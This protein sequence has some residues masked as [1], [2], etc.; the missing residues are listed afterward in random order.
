MRTTCFACLFVVGLKFE[1]ESHFYGF[2][3]VAQ[4]CQINWV[5][6]A[7]LLWP[8]ERLAVAGRRDVVLR[9]LDDAK[10]PLGSPECSGPAGGV[11]WAATSSQVKWLMS[12]VLT[13]G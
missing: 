13:L 2:L 8:V 11:R 1:S 10:Y 7:V 4:S 5:M 12:A 3:V 9:P 6:S